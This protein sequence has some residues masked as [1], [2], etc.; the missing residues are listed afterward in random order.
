MDC[1]FCKIIEGK[2]PSQKIYEDSDVVAIKD[3]QPQSPIHYLFIPRQHFSGLGDIPP[4]SVL[5]MGRIFKAIQTVAKKEGFLEK[6]FRTV[7][8]TNKEGCQSV[9]HLHV[10]GG[11]INL[12][13]PVPF[14][15]VNFILSQNS[16]ISIKVFRPVPKKSRASST[17]KTSWVSKKVLS[18]FKRLK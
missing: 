12:E 2:I 3:I 7:I 15:K 9:L 16:N 14:R 8:N 6:G 4:E 1:L 10:H 5:V 18:Q 17:V 11:S 13:R